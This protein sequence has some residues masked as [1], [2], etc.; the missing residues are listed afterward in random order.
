MSTITWGAVSLPMPLYDRGIEVVTGFLGSSVETEDGSTRLQLVDDGQKNSIRL[1]WQD[2][3]VAERAT[4][5]SAFDAYADTATL[6]TLPDGQ[7]FT[8]YAIVSG[9]KERHWYDTGGVAYYNI[10]LR[11]DE[12]S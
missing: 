1:R 6:L 5:R 3:S 7:S 10:E 11:F 8:V 4:L 12:S 9:W 2:L